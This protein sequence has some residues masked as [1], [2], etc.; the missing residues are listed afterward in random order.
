M[1]HIAR[2]IDPKPILPENRQLFS[3]KALKAMIVPLLI[4]QLLQLVVGIAW[5]MV[6]DWCLK[7]VLDVIRFKGG[8]WR[9]KQVI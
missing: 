6:L 8:K 9:D 2:F 3:N 7:A 4:E 1:E 5:A